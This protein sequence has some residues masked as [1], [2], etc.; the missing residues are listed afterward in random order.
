MSG[1]ACR[2]TALAF[3]RDDVEMYAEGLARTSV[4][5][6]LLTATGLYQ[7][8]LKLNPGLKIHIPRNALGATERIGDTIVLFTKT[9]Y[10]KL[11]RDMGG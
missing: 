8:V 4:A 6:G 7:Y 2:S 5:R 1:L 9:S 11:L 3:F 10:R